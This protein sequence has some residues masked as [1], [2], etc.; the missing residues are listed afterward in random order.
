MIGLFDS[1]LGGLTVLRRV[2]ERLPDID[3]LFFADQ[4]H[5]PY[6]DRTADDLFALL[7]SN[8]AWLDERGVE[9]I[10][11][12]CNTSCAIADLYGWPTTQAE[13]FDL[14]D[15]ATIALQQYGARRIGVVATAATVRSGAYGRRIRNAMHESEV[16]EVAAPELV[17]LVEAGEIESGVACDAV[18]RYCAELPPDLDAV[19]YGCTHYPVLERHFRA[20]LGE[21]VALIDPAVIQAARL[22]EFVQLDEAPIG[23]GTTRYVTSGDPERFR[24]SVAAIMDE[25]TPVILSSRA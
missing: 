17:P 8:L 24:L 20:A 11:M 25:R 16:W 21:R 2:R 12:A 9:A 1:G 22:A 14:L 5:V 18:M 3:V 6:G 13:I 4:A 7:Q 10:V 19:V 15:S 23:S